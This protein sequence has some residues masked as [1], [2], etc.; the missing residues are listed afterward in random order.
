MN[1]KVVRKKCSSFYRP[2]YL[3][4]EFS[5]LARL[6]NPLSFLSLHVSTVNSGRMQKIAYSAV[7]VCAHF[8]RMY[9]T[10]L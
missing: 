6:A 4:Y 7:P 10:E 1:R 5:G 9:S 2:S 3:V 8:T